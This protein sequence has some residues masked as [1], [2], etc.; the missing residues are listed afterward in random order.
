MEDESR[1]NAILCPPGTWNEFGKET[2]KARCNPCAENAI[3]YGQVECSGNERNWEKKILDKLF[4]MT[5]GRYWNKTHDNWQKPGVPICEREGVHCFNQSANEGVRELQMNA[6]GLR[7]TIPTD[8]WKLT[9]ARLLSFTNNAVDVSFD[10]I[11]EAKSLIVLK[12]S[13]CNLRTLDGLGVAPKTLK[14]LHVAANQFDGKIPHGIYELD[15]VVKLFLNNNHFSGRIPSEMGLL[16]AVTELFLQNNRLTGMLPSEL[17]LITNLASLSVSQNELSGLIPR[18]IQNLQQLSRLEIA[19]QKGN[20][21]NGPL[22]AFDESPLL[23]Y[24]DA[25]ENSFSGYLPP[26]FLSQ[27]NVGEKIFVNLSQNRFEGPVPVYWSKFES[28][29]IDLSGNLLTGLPEALCQNNDWNNG[30]V[31]LLGTCD[32]ILC[33]PGTHLEDGRQTSVTTSCQSCPGGEDSAP[34]F[35]TRECIDP[36]LLKE[37]K[38]LVD[39]YSASNGTNWLVQTNWLSNYPTCSWYGVKCN[40]DGFV[41][42]LTLENNKLESGST[43]IVSKLFSLED[44]KVRIYD[45]RKRPRLK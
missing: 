9:S 38:I 22:P 27:V 3:L 15:S 39:F 21:F 30:L 13:N 45:E 26:Y 8:I 44:L 37:R 18:E 28:L 29:N 40:E 4:S 7:G 41:E 34:Y 35:G 36:K 1:C 5:G 23:A 6:F 14:E 33:P 11:E 20:Q 42:E 10:G 31:G 16:T 25:S 19:Q 43:N 17:G 24:M 12:L 2:E 32:A